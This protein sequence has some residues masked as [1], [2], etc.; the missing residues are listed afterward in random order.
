MQW[1]QSKVLRPDSLMGFSNADKG[2]HEHWERGDNLLNFPH[3]FRALVTGPPNVGKSTTVKNILVRQEPP[4]E[5]VI[6]VHADPEHTKEYDDLKDDAD[7]DAV[8]LIPEIP[9]P[10]SWEP[11]LNEDGE[12]VLP[13]TLLVVDDLDLRTLNREQKKNLDRL[14]GYCSTHRSISVIICTQD[15]FNAAPNVRRMCNLFVIWQSPDLECMA[16]IAKKVGVKDLQALF[17]KYCRTRRDS[18]WIDLTV[19]TPAPLRLNG[20]TVIKI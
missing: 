4:F 11:Q 13:K 5:R 18:I 10:D 16:I 7:E 14:T 1:A 2:F 12:E 20:F 15:S 8:I 17:D 6:I 19:D 9:P 3:P